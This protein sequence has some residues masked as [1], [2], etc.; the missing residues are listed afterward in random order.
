MQRAKERQRV[1]VDAR[2]RVADLGIVIL[3]HPEVQRA[4]RVAHHIGDAVVADRDAEILRRDVFELMRLV[5]DRVVAVGDH[6]AVGALAHR[7]VGAQQVV[8]DDHDVGF[9]GASAASS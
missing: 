8:I 2:D 9:G 6:L 4:L 7:R 3:D 1:I 5:D